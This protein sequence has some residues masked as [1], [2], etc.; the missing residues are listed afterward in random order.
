MGLIVPHMVRLV[1][2]PNHRKML[3]TT[4][5][6]G[7]IFLMLTD[8]MARTVLSPIELPIGMVTSLIGAVMFVSIFY[9]SRKGGRGVC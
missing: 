2:G 1:T 9:R 6:S 8:L 3:P 5:F 4:V 7:A